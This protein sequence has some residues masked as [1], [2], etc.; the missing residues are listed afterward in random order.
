MVVGKPSHLEIVPERWVAVPEGRVALF[1]RAGRGRAV[2]YVH[3]ATFPTALSVGWDV[4]RAVGTLPESA[5]ENEAETAGSWMQNLVAAGLDVYSLDFIGYGASSRWPAASE[6]PGR[7]S[8]AV[9]QLAAVV[10]AV[11]SEAGVAQVALLAHS[12]GTLVAGRFASQWPERVARLVLFGPITRREGEHA[13]AALPPTRDISA[14]QQWDRFQAEVPPGAAP[15]LTRDAFQPWAA[16]YLAT[17]CAS[18]ARVPPAVRVPGGPFLDIADA[19]AG[20]LAYDPAQVRAP[21]LLIRGAWDTLAT[22]R[23][24]SWLADALAG[25]PTV[26]Q[27]SLSGGTHVMHLEAG[28]GRLWRHVASFLSAGSEGRR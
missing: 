21:V 24:V 10:D 25:A 3:G 6:P 2:V 16:A 14:Q 9:A 28:R 1:H 23:D 4:R 19:H 18:G 27:V 15:V 26:D 20:H 13:P 5:R 17:D 7:V 12:W 22:R 8:A 11:R